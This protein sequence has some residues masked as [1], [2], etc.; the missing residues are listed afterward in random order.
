[1][2][3]FFI[4]IFI[5]CSAA[6]AHDGAHGPEQKMAPHGGI[7]RDSSSLMF[8]LVKD[9]NF[10]IYPITHAGKAIDPKQVEIDFKK[11][12]L[13]DVK[14]KVVAYTIVIDGAAFVL[15][16]EKGVSH[17]YALNLVARYEGKENKANWQIEITAE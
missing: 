15:K 3:A 16:F 8:E 17:R 9:Q 13:Q 5:C 1:M 11:T 2:R 6:F 12:T 7:L 10:K 14:K 4:F